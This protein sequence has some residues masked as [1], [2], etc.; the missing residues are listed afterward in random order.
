MIK[1]NSIV[2]GDSLK[3]LKKIP[4]RSIDLIFADP[5]YNLQLKDTLYRPDQTEVEAVT[6]DWDKFDTY[7]TYD[8][9]C[10]S[11][12]KECK[13][14]LKVGGAL[15]VIGSYHNILRLGTGIQNLGFWILND[16]VWHKTNP[17]PNFRGTR[18]TNAHETLLWCTTSRDAKYTFN[19]QNLKELNEG[20][21]MRSDWYIPICS[22]KERLRKSNNQRSHPTQKPEALLYRILLASSKKGDLILDP[23]LGSGT[24]AVV[25][26]KLQRNFIGIE[27]DINYIKLS[28][29]RLKKTKVLTE[30]LVTLNQSRKELP[31][32]PFGELV[33]QGIIPPGA[34]LTDKKERFKATVKIDGSLKIDNISGSIHQVGA[35]VQGL[36]SCNGWDFWHIKNKS[37]FTLL[38]NVR[39]KYRN[40]KTPIN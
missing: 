8:K 37:S 9:F 31:K 28:K 20:K 40:K 22:G 23:F 25:A 6:N 14:I 1:K 18:F 19:Y 29:K 38:D 4:D 34:V 21:Q 7:K 30:D 16:I 2:Q 12:L 39:D 17:M 27:K 33:E 32:V 26:K 3:I 10:L 5:P 11:W 15:W 24:S 36:P 13:R 35:K